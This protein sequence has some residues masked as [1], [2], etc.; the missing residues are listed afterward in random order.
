MLHWTSS[1]QLVPYLIFATAMAFLCWVIIATVPA[2]SQTNSGSHVA[3]G[4][5]GIEVRPNGALKIPDS[6]GIY[7]LPPGRSAPVQRTAD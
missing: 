7:A 4:N 5:I 3:A 1:P 6:A 2:H